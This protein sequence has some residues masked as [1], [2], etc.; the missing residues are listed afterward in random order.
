MSS[1]PRNPSS[2]QP[3]AGA[4]VAALLLTLERPA[5]W[6]VALAG[7]LARGGVVALV[8][9]I[10]A[11]PTPAGLQ[12]M[13]SPIIVPF[14]FGDVAPGFVALVASLIVAGL[15]WLA[16]GGLVGAWSEAHL[17]RAAA[18]EEQ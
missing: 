11:L 14:H 10:L 9:P 17:V 1:A 6:A 15:T 4:V 13:I 2:A 16:V 3:W 8:L 12:T 5:G 18:V 7:F